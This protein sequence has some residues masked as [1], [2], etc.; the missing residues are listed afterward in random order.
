MYRLDKYIPIF[1]L[2]GRGEKAG[3]I[4]RLDTVKICY[5]LKKDFTIAPKLYIV[6]IVQN[7][8]KPI[9]LSDPIELPHGSSMFPLTHVADLPSKKFVTDIWMWITNYEQMQEL[10][11]IASIYNVF[12][13]PYGKVATAE[14][15][16]CE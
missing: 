16:A 15:I 10:I 14:A 9:L 5:E 8:T 4:L 3:A 12:E 2:L 7:T 6:G 1:E 11:D 13:V